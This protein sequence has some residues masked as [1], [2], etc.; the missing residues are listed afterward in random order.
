MIVCSCN[1]LSDHDVRH[2]VNTAD[3]APRNATPLARCARDVA[4]LL[5]V[6]AG[7][8]ERDSTSA[9]VR[10]IDYESTLESP[11]RGKRI[12]LLM[13]TVDEQ[14]DDEVRDQVEAASSIFR[15]L[16]CEVRPVEFSTRAD[17]D[18][19]SNIVVKS[20]GAGSHRNR[21]S[22]RAHEYARQARGRL[23]AGLMI[24]AAVYWQAMGLRTHML[25]KFMTESYRASTQS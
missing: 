14:I 25:H 8:D 9:S 22:A 10:T 19:L 7:S 12:G 3:D 13:S 23:E 6:I 5:T 11:I 21:L 16:G 20:E 4:R 2:A 17:C 18:D 1:V 15:G 24:P